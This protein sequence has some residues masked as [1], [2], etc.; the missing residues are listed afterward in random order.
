MASRQFQISDGFVVVFAAIILKP[1][2]DLS[3]YSEDTDLF[4]QVMN[5]YKLIYIPGQV[6][7]VSI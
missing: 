3:K 6:E 1:S 7:L 2:A 5:E 4:R